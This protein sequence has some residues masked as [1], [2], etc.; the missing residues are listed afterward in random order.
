MFWFIFSY[1]DGKERI[2]SFSVDVGSELEGARIIP[3]SSV[4]NNLLL[5][6]LCVERPLLECLE[7]DQELD[8]K[9]D[10]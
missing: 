7:L 1:W 4:F 6:W 5:E 2:G 10:Q 3:D 9:R 8:Q